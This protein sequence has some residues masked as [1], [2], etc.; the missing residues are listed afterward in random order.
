MRSEKLNKIENWAHVLLFDWRLDQDFAACG[1][2]FWQEIGFYAVCAFFKHQFLSSFEN[3]STNSTGCR[4][5]CFS[6]IVEMIDDHFLIASIDSKSYFSSLNQGFF[7]RIEWINCILIHRMTLS[8]C[9]V[10]LFGFNTISIDSIAFVGTICCCCCCL[11]SNQSGTKKQTNKIN[12]KMFR[13]R[14]HLATK[15]TNVEP[16]RMLSEWNVRLP[17]ATKAIRTER[18]CTRHNR[19][20]SG[21]K[22]LFLVDWSASQQRQ[23]QQQQI[24]WIYRICLF[25]SFSKSIEPNQCVQQLFALPWFEKVEKYTY[26][27]LE[28]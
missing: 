23:Y 20:A 14:F 7:R 10:A 26:T 8:I 15:S 1:Q 24:E 3:A 27:D 21:Q 19:Y 4:K 9:V 6:N 13:F 22:K 17:A 12:A 2:L 16:N 28:R 5:F 25:L 18:A 11:R